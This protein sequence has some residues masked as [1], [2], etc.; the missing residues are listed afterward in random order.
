MQ[1][2]DLIYYPELSS[3]LEQIHHHVNLSLSVHTRY[4]FFF[5][6]KTEHTRYFDRHLT[7]THPTPLP[8]HAPAG[9]ISPVAAGDHP[10]HSARVDLGFLFPLLSPPE[11][12]RPPACPLASSHAQGQNVERRARLGGAGRYGGTRA[13]DGPAGGGAGGRGSGGGAFGRA[14]AAVRRACRRRRV[15]SRRREC[16]R[17]SRRAPGLA[18]LVGTVL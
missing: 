9:T 8:L 11:P 16:R 18:W 4:F 13:G 12:Q 10:R 2:M 5:C 15:P 6:L 7:L 14:P 3:K 17:L 1:N